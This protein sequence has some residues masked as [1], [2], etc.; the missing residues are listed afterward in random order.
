[1]VFSRAGVSYNVTLKLHGVEI[2]RVSEIKI[3]GN[4]FRWKTVESTYRIEYCISDKNNQ[5]S[6]SLFIKLENC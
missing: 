3:L 1:M 2:E 4:N 5:N 6:L